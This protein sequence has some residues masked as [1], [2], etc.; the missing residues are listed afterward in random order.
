[1]SS[2]TITGASQ[3][4]QRKVKSR[5]MYCVRLFSARAPFIGF[6]CSC[7][8]RSSPAFRRQVSRLP[9][10]HSPILVN[11][12]CRRCETQFFVLAAREFHLSFQLPA[13]TANDEQLPLHTNSH[14]LQLLT[15][16]NR[17]PTTT[18]ADGQPST[19]TSH[20]SSTEPSPT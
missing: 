8:V 19:A 15:T 13:S 2:T 6:E 1:M 20:G 14:L 7:F 11:L 10:L 17:Q 5:R 4:G 9:G 3:K 12:L 16:I 18:S